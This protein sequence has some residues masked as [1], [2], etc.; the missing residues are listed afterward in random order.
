MFVALC[1]I[2]TLEVDMSAPVRNFLARR[3]ENRQTNVSSEWE[4]GGSFP[5]GLLGSV[6]VEIFWSELTITRL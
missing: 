4:G 2:V 3:Q 5:Q 6:L 1:Y